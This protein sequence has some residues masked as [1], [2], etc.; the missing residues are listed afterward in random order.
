MAEARNFDVSLTLAKHVL[1]NHA[2]NSNVI[3]S[4]ISIETVLS[5][6]A[7]GSSGTTLDQLLSFLNAKDLYDLKFCYSSRIRVFDNGSSSDGLS[8][9]FANGVWLD[10]SL[11]MKPYFNHVVEAVFMAVPDQL[12]FQSQVRVF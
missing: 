7:A 10:K 1:L 11:S 8:L 6:V 4:P 2:N 9:L 12:D 3:F 5:M